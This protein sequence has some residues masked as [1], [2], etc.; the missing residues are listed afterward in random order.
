[1]FNEGEIY[2]RR[3]LHKEYGGQ[4]QGGISTPSKFPFIMIFTGESGSEYGYKD[5]WQDNGI[6][7][8]TGEGQEGPMQFIRGNK[9]IRDHIKN[10]KDIYLF[11]YVRQA[12]VQYLTQVVCI[13][14]HKRTTHDHKGSMR[15]AIVFEFL[16][17]KENSTPSQDRSEVETSVNDDDSLKT[18]R[19]KALV[20][21][22]DTATATIKEKVITTYT[23]SIA[24][25]KYARKRANGICEG[26]SNQAPFK[27]INGQPYLEVH[28]LRR[29]SDGGPD[30]PEWVAALCPTCHMRCHHAE[31]GK[32][33]NNS[34]IGKISEIER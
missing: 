1:M 23:R 7:Y 17:V 3:E 25:K 14:Y 21:S 27:A 32:E 11:E 15:E 6:F 31:D 30:H 18:L 13:G 26:C 2:R 22:S 34:I 4:Q 12:Y 10:G 19:E 8:Y 5:G 33:Y 9:A 28:H 24:I 29:L 16:P 20:S